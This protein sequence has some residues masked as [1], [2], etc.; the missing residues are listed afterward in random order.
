MSPSV[1]NS[2]AR[3]DTI[4]VDAKT[5]LPLGFDEDDPSAGGVDHSIYKNMKWHA[6]LTKAD[7]DWQ[8]PKD[9]KLLKQPG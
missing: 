5:F 7:L 4:F 1:S 8:P 2:V 9:A 3:G 6:K